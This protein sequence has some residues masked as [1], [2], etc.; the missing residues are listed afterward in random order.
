MACLRFP[1]KTASFNHYHP[2]HPPAKKKKKKSSQ[3]GPCNRNITKGTPSKLPSEFYQPKSLIQIML[4]VWDNIHT[5]P[6]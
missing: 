2:A 5:D 4:Y 3:A 1:M 6:S